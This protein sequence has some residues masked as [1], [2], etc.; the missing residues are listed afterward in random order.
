[1]RVVRD[2]SETLPREKKSVCPCSVCSLVKVG[3]HRR[4]PNRFEKKCTV[5]S[6][7]FSNY[8]HLDVTL[9]VRRK[10]ISLKFIPTSLLVKE[11]IEQYVAEEYSQRPDFFNERVRIGTYI[12]RITDNLTN[13]LH[14]KMS[15]NTA[16]CGFNGSVSMESVAYDTNILKKEDKLY[17]GK[18]AGKGRRKRINK[19]KSESVAVMTLGENKKR[20]RKKG[21]HF[22]ILDIAPTEGTGDVGSIKELDFKPATKSE[23]SITNLNVSVLVRFLR[24]IFR[25]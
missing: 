14:Q 21:E 1:M 16:E 24:F 5:S 11:H 20:R 8:Y 6:S 4:I 9:N 3:K 18:V 25:K 13:Y 17:V 19:K 2:M 22:S 7:A 10:K 12:S 15:G 23:A